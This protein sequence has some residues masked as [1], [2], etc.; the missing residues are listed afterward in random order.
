MMQRPEE[1]FNI[2]FGARFDAECPLSDGRDKYLLIQ[3][4]APCRHE[5]ESLEA[6]CG[7]NRRIDLSVTLFTQA[8]LDIAAQHG[9][10]EIGPEMEQ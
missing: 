6:G 8:S 4:M 2:G 9:D 1:F 10:V 5:T 3:D 7:Q